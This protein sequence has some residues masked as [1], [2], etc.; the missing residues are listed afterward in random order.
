MS[1]LIPF[2]GSSGGSVATRPAYISGNW[3]LPSTGVLSAGQ[4]QAKDI[5]RFI[6]FMCTSDVTIHTLGVRITTVGTSNIQLA[7][8]ANQQ[9]AGEGPRPANILSSTGSIVNTA[10][11]SV[12]A[13]LGADVACTSG[14]LYWLGI[15][16]ND[17]ASAMV[18]VSQTSTSPILATLAGSVTQSSILTA[19][20]TVITFLTTPLTFNTWGDLTAAT[21][22]EVS[23]QAFAVIQFKVA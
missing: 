15:N 11:A 13:N 5:A 12:N 8:Y 14:T 16:N 23:S 4:A 1:G 3:Y 18:C 10:A 21:W 2:A 9:K 22:A 7:I 20:P 17:A 19:T 6:P